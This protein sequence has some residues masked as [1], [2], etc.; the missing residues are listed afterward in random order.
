MSEYLCVYIAMCDYLC[1]FLKNMSNYDYIF[2]F[3]A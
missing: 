3:Y 1:L 2:L